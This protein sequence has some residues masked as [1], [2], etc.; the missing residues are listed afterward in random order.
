[1]RV[2]R[3][4][5]RFCPWKRRLLSPQILVARALGNGVP[6]YCHRPLAALLP[7]FDL[8]TV[9][10]APFVWRWDCCSFLGGSA[11]P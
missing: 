4:G 1:M 10:H 6:P 11:L 2:L 8:A 3:G 7:R 5:L 9:P